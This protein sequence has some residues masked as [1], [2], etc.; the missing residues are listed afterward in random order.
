[1]GIADSHWG[2]TIKAVIVLREGHTATPA[3]IVSWCRENLA[4]YKRP[5]FIE[6]VASD[7]L[8]RSTTGKIL[9]HELARRPVGEEQ[10]V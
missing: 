1:L 2:E 6:I 10:R 4:S 9:R 8:P 7:E 3:G 5:R